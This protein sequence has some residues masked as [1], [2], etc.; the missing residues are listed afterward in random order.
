MVPGIF[1]GS[2]VL[3][4]VAIPVAVTLAGLAVIATALLMMATPTLRIRD[5]ARLPAGVGAGF[6]GGLLGGVAAMPGPF[7]FIY[8]LARGSRGRSFT[9]EASLFL[10]LSA[11]LMALTLT[12]SQRFDW[13]DL[14][15]STLALAPVGFG[16]VI[17]QKLRD[18]LPTDTF[19]QFV[20][21]AVLLAGL[22][23]LY[24]GIFL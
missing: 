12:A 10:V 3:L 8:L 20:L 19:K 4:H 14:G 13:T 16:M 7:V 11:A 6:F 24:R 22:Q 15:L 2:A 18:A 21:G 9:K 1:L 5:E 23:L 17:G